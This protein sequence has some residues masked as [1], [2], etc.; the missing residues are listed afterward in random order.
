MVFHAPGQASALDTPRIA[1]GADIG[2]VAV[3]DADLDGG[4]LRFAKQG[5]AFVDA[6][7]GSRWDILGNAIDGPA[8]G[9]SLTPVRFLDTFW[10]A[11]VAFHPDTEL[12]R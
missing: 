5:D 6:G 7:T 4:S 9:Q 1:D 12:R 2:T 8:L 11:W 3:Y 10:F